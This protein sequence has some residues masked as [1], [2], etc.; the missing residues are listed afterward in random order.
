[1]RIV[2]L[3][4]QSFQLLGLFFLSLIFC[5]VRESEAIKGKLHE[6]FQTCRKG[7]KNLEEPFCFLG[8]LF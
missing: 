2:G 3:K 4:T 5:V 1:M 8:H 6:G 7:E